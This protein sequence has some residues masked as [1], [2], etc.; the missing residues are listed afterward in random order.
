MSM[1]VTCA[2][3]A[4]GAVM[5]YIDCCLCVTGGGRFGRHLWDITA[6]DIVKLASL[7]VCG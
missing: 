7:I 5:Y 6:G 4:L 1:P 2:L 3:A